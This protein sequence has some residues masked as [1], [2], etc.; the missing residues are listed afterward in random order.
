MALCLV[1]SPCVFLSMCKFI[2][3]TSPFSVASPVFVTS[4]VSVPCDFSVHSFVFV[5]NPVSPPSTV[6]I[7]LSQCLNTVTVPCPVSKLSH[8][9]VACPILYVLVL[10]LFPLD[11]SSVC[12]ICSFVFIFPHKS[13]LLCF[14]H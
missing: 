5:S 6:L 9:T 8:V 14:N 7:V 2:S 12:I 13:G 10:H 3:L 1:L 4:L 11:E